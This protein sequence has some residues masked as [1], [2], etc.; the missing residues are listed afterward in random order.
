MKISELL[1]KD[2]VILDIAAKE[3]GDILAEM[4]D[5]LVSAGEVKKTDKNEIVKKLKEREA[6]GSTGI[7]KGVAIPHA[8]C[9]KIK[10]ITAAFGIS[11][12]GVDFKSLDG[13]PTYIFFLLIAPGETPGPHLKVLA[14]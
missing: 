9:P 10:K 7:G 2:V 1:G 4:V 8:K 14:K 6:L 5:I 3:K 11:K 12:N 13:E